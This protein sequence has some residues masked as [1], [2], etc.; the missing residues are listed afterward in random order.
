[1]LIRAKVLPTFVDKYDVD[2]KHHRVEFGDR[3]LQLRSINKQE[4]MW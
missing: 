3:R 4:D 2:I 1:M